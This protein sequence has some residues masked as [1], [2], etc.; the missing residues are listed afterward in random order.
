[1]WDLSVRETLAFITC[2]SKQQHAEYTH[3][4]THFAAYHCNYEVDASETYFHTILKQFRMCS[5]IEYEMIDLVISTHTPDMLNH[6][7]YVGCAGLNLA[8]GN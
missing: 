3:T 4:Q 6:C 2:N 5:N 8:L 7:V 1:M